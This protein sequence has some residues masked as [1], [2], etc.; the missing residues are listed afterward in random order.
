MISKENLKDMYPLS[1]MQEGM[2]YHAVAD[3]D[4]RAY[5]E[6]I[7]FRISGELDIGKFMEAWTEIFRRHDILRTAFL[8]EKASRPLQIV[9]KERKP[10]FSVDDI[11]AE[12]EE[13]KERTVI[14]FREE[15]KQR[16]FD[17]ARDP[18]MRFRVIVLG[19]GRFEVIWS[20]SH[21][22]MDGWG[23]SLAHTEFFEIYTAL[24]EGRAHTLPPAPPYSRFIQWLEERDKRASLDYWE[25]YLADYQTAVSIPKL[26]GA[27][28]GKEFA[29]AIHS[30]TLGAERVRKVEQLAAAHAVTPN[31]VFQAAL[32]VALCMY[33]G[34]DDA[35]FGSVVSGRPPEL[36]GAEKTLG[37]FINTIPVRGSVDWDSGLDVLL[38]R[39]MKS[40]VESAPH[41]HSFLGEVIGR[42]TPGRDL[43]SALLIFEN[44]PLDALTMLPS[45]GFDIIRTKRFEM[46]TSDF[47]VVVIPGGDMRVD[48][49]YNQNVHS[50]AQVERTASHLVKILDFAI[51]G[52]SRPLSMLKVMDDEEMNAVTI[53][54]Q[55][56][57]AAIP[58]GKTV[59]AMFTDSAL[60]HGDRIAAMD[61]AGEVTY[62]RLDRM[63]N[64]V[65]RA[66][67]EKASVGKGDVVAA[68]V[69]RSRWL[70]A[71]FMGILKAGG[72][73]LPCDP[74]LP[75]E[76]IRFMM[77]DSACKAVIVDDAGVA[78]QLADGGVPV[79]MTDDIKESP[80]QSA[81]AADPEEPA[82]LIYTSGSTGVPKGALISHRAAINLSMWHNR[83]YKVDENSRGTLHA[84]PSF[85]A[86]VWETL[87]YLFAGASLCAVEGET[88]TDM[89]KLASFYQDKRITHSFLPPALL[90]QFLEE[91]GGS[92]A[93][94]ITIVTGGETLKR[95][96]D[97]S[98]LV[99]N[100]YGPTEC[101]VAATAVCLDEPRLRECIPIGRPIDNVKVYILDSRMRPVPIGAIGEIYIGGAGVGNGYVNRPELTAAAFAPG[102]FENGAKLYRTGDMARWRDDGLIDFTGRRD[103]Q[104]KIRGNRVETGEIE[105]LLEGHAT[106]TSAAVVARDDGAGSKELAA[107]YVS[108]KEEDV[109]DLRAHLASRVPEY[110]IP[111][112]FIRMEKLPLASSG[113]VDRSA[114]EAAAIAA[115]RPQKQGGAPRNPAETRMLEI[116]AGVMGV[117]GAGIFDNF[118]DLGGHSIKA[119]Q[120]ASRIRKEFGVEMPPNSIFEN[121]TVESICQAMET[122]K[123]AAPGN[124]G[125]MIGK[126]PRGRKP[127][128]M[129]S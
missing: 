68:V 110:M 29:V 64:G 40:G 48:Y 91:N 21:I 118:F 17:L 53:G 94:K 23:I 59:D 16:G 121:P 101:A 52:A 39:L 78:A 66:L 107:F 112:M 18:L 2:L 67:I 37:L 89:A 14:R 108:G 128:V 11:S 96:G 83:F 24:K 54:F 10:G 33:N 65:A 32:S 123:Q 7:S 77:R 116:W 60:K 50:A 72:L 12:P 74:D 3:R 126:A 1:P 34:V 76:R 22:V 106:V 30:S 98:V 115:A 92:L 87:P 75:A 99:A 19:G 84:S 28:N 5:F 42:S 38:K 88:R 69:H 35:V 56:K 27:P 117:K 57:S 100:N 20:L 82:Y 102:P 109:A 97:G 51:E 8:L 13:E 47:N 81:A 43:I 93:G 6:Q 70:A 4:S 25:K 114:L 104:V 46:T 120:L 63:A 9:L 61:G 58:E 36:P 127:A 79:I 103:G 113:K 125:Q 31:M 95:A 41:H 15:D 45:T 73:Y 119:A 49:H 129:D 90:T 105:K 86:S 122:V 111:S 44:Y 26:P 85:D 124:G 62:Q 55:G 71:S 80:A